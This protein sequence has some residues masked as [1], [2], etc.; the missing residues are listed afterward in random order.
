MGTDIRPL[1]LVVR[2]RL[3][4]LLAA[5]FF[6]YLPSLSCVQTL[7]IFHTHNEQLADREEMVI[8]LEKTVFRMTFSSFK[9]SAQLNCTSSLAGELWVHT[10]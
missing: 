1:L 2:N 8:E 10:R 3:V 5:L 4:L 7:A 6:S 9:L